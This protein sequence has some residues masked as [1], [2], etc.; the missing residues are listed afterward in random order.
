MTTLLDSQLYEE[1]DPRHK[2]LG[3]MQK[4]LDL[5]AKSSDNNMS[6]QYNEFIQEFNRLTH[7]VLAIEADLAVLLGGKDAVEDR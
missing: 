7:N 3:K 5:A 1:T 2:E 4:L 6:E